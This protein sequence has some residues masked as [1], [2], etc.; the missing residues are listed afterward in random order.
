M[1]FLN[2]LHLIIFSHHSI[3]YFPG[4][5]HTPSYGEWFPIGWWIWS[6][7][8]LPRLFLWSNYLWNASASNMH[9]NKTENFNMT[10]ND[11]CYD[12]LTYC[13]WHH[14]QL[15]TYAKILMSSLYSLS[16]Q[17]LMSWLYSLSSP[18]SQL[19]SCSIL[20]PK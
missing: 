1:I 20:L 14:Q 7:Y 5:S 10:F 17:I 6:L 19:L 8:V 15:S 16:W 2:I 9:F 13:C 18:F 4:W 11:L 3:N 12:P